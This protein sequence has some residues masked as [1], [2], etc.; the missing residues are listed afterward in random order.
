M[1]KHL[2]S[3]KSTLLLVISSGCILVCRNVEEE[4]MLD[5]VDRSKTPL[6]VAVPPDPLDQDMA[7]D[8]RRCIN[9]NITSHFSLLLMMALNSLWT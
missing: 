3:C 7:C 5:K 6:Q 8:R 2:L 9:N 4:I 1:M